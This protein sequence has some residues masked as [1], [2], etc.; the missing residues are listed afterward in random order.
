MVRGGGG[1]WGGTAAGLAGL[2]P[3]VW[4]PSPSGSGSGWPGVPHLPHLTASSDPRVLPQPP[5]RLQDGIFRKR[6]E[7]ERV[8]GA[9]S[10]LGAPT[11]FGSP[12]FKLTPSPPDVGWG[13]GQTSSLG[14]ELGSGRAAPPSGTRF[15]LAFILKLTERHPAHPPGD[16]APKRTFFQTLAGGQPGLCLPG[17]RM[18]YLAEKTPGMEARGGRGVGCGG[19][20]DLAFTGVGAELR[21]SFPVIPRLA[22]P[23]S[24]SVWCPRPAGW[25]QQE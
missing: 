13:W 24:G 7:V 9:G 15:G 3:R 16:P 18:T 2:W 20:S 11:A 12:H 25:A 22:R 10:R 17:L 1:V 14:L 23:P 21:V 5:P 8:E 6:L 4:R 19:G